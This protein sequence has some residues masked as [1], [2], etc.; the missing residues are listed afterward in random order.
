MIAS[1][2]LLAIIVIQ[3]TEWRAF[4]YSQSLG[5]KAGLKPFSLIVS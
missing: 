2:L 5:L 4:S 1:Q 3:K